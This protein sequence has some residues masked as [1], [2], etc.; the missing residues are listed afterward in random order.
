[1]LKER[2]AGHAGACRALQT[3]SCA[4][5][6]SSEQIRHV[7]RT[8]TLLLVSL[9]VQDAVAL[10][11]AS[12][13]VRAARDERAQGWRVVRV[14]ERAVGPCWGL[15]ASSSGCAA[16]RNLQRVVGLYHPAATPLDACGVA[17]FCP[18]RC[19]VLASARCGLVL[20]P[21]LAE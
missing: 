8:E 1:M 12:I 15:A 17:F 4:T 7:E 2:C 16:L 10:S 9:R 13:V 18:C 20:A 3:I 21:D 6:A 19:I 5:C 14:I 11:A